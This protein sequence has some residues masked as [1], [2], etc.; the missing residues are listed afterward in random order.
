MTERLHI[1]V[2]IMQAIP[3]EQQFPLV[4]IRE[5]QGF[6]TTLAHLLYAALTEDGQGWERAKEEAERIM[7]ADGWKEY[8]TTLDAVRMR[9]LPGFHGFPHRRLTGRP[10]SSPA[11]SEAL[12]PQRA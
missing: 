4:L 9:E 12:C 5:K 2:T 10:R 11:H 1:H 6:F 8:L 7:L 3:E